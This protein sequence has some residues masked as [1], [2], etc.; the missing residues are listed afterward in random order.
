MV[1]LHN[2]AA[3]MFRN[4]RGFVI[5]AALSVTTLAQADEPAITPTSK[6]ADFVK[7]YVWGVGKYRTDEHTKMTG[8][9][10]GKSWH[11]G[12]QQGEDDGISLVWQGEREQMSISVDGIRFTRRF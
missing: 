2:L 1:V 9:R 7:S 8:W 10:L 12:Y 11:F 3:K 4:V 5:I 6:S